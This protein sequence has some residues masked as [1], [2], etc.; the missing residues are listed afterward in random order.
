MKNTLLRINDTLYRVCIGIA[1]LSVL[2]M[3]LIIPWGIFAR[4]VLGSGSSWPE[5]VAILLMVVFTFFGAAASYRAGAHMAVAMAVDRMPLQV[6]KVATVIV[7]I[8][9]AIVALFMIVK[10]FKLCATTWNQF[11]GEIPS[12]RVGISYLPIPIGGIVTLIFVLERMFL[13]DQSHRSV[14]R[15]DVIEESEGAA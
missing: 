14:M 6:R 5:P 13:G 15:F 9:M 3:T 11:L 4:Y 7:Q 10:G 8:L 1:G 2:I 12:L